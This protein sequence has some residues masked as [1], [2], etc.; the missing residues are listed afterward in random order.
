MLLNNL[1]AKGNTA[2][3]YLSD[4]KVIKVFNDGLPET[5]AFYEADRQR[6]AYDCGLPVP[7]VYDVITIDGKQA[8]IMEN[9]QGSTLGD[10][11]NKD[12]EHAKRYLQISVDVQMKIHAVTEKQAGN[13]IREEKA[14][15]GMADKLASQIRSARFP[16]S[17]YMEVLIREL[18]SRTF[19]A[20]FCHG[21][22]HVFNI[23][24]Q[25]GTPV[26]IDWV[27]SSFGDV[28]ADVCRSYL[29][30]SAASWELADLYLDLYCKKSGISKPEIVSWAPVIA[31]A[32]LSENV[33]AEHAKSL[34]QIVCGFCQSRGEIPSL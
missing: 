5:Q 26:V 10:M 7:R 33:P 29:L 34:L 4:H 18:C 13:R 17:R 25:D 2:S 31:G 30:Y 3:V 11:L 21:D 12:K 6:F 23:I 8:L 20:N 22:F 19:P 28:C 16:D 32:R 24:M 14:Q 27:D 9:I 15:Y 1:I